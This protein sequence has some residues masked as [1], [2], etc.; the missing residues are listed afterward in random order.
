MS[1]KHWIRRLPG[2]S[3]WAKRVPPGHYFRRLKLSEG[4][5]VLPYP[6]TSRWLDQFD[7]A[8]LLLPLVFLLVTSIVGLYTVAPRLDNSPEGTVTWQMIIS[9]ISSI[10]LIFSILALM[11]LLQLQGNI[12]GFFKDLL[13]HL[14]TA[15]E[16]AIV[17]LSPSQLEARCIARLQTLAD[18]VVQAEHEQT[19]P[20]AQECERARDRMRQAYWF[21]RNY[22]FIKEMP[23]ERFFGAAQR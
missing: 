13:H 7:W 8:C 11:D 10:G 5:G 18:L 21:F 19:S 12:N 9:L 15:D 14:D 16:G 3:R 17:S 4:I 6:W 2:A 20:M 1:L 23:W 22:S